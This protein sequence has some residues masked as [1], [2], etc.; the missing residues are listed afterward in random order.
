MSAANL[1]CKLFVTDLD[2]TILVDEGPN[3]V[4]L[5]ERTKEALSRLSA[6]GVTVCLASGRM[7]ESIRVVADSWGFKGPIISYNGAMIRLADEQL[8]SHEPLDC[9]VS[10]QVV[11]FAEAN[12]LPLNFYFEGRI[13]SRRFHPWWDRYEGRTCSPM[14]EVE[15]LLPWRGSSATK[16]LLMSEPPRILRFEAEFKARFGSSATVLISSDEYLEFMSPAVNKGAALARLAAHLGVEK[17]E[18]VA[19]GD[20]YNDIEMLQASGCSL[21]VAGG[22]QALKDLADHVVAGP[23]ES[24]VAQFIETHLLA[25]R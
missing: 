20:G 23:E 21:A 3:G 8:L 6:Q 25:G 15:S 9:A 19:A 7:H 16:L 12:G 2:G 14:V 17:H 5:P 22:R 24:G 18:I 10:D 13:L 11:E 4:R 1:S